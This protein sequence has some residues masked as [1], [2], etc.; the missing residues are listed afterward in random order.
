MNTLLG[1][2]IQQTQAFLENGSR[3]PV[4][5]VMASDNPVLGIKTYATHSALMLGFGKR[6]KPTKA[7]FGIAKKANLSDVPAVIREVRVDEVSV[8][9]GE[10]IKAADVFKPGDIVS[11]TGQSKGKG[12]AGGVKRYHFKGGPRTHGQSDRERAPG[13]IGQTTTPGRVYRGK[14]MAGN[15]GHEQVTVQNLVVIDVDD[16][17]K[18]LLL[19]GLVPGVLG[20]MIKITKTGEVKEKNFSPL[21]KLTDPS[22]AVEETVEEPAVEPEAAPVVETAQEEVTPDEAQPAAEEAPVAAQETS[23]ENDAKEATNNG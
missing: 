15:M 23:E 21:F 7:L 10:S 16:V 20:G 3:I 14:R 8:Q 6:K 18:T 12:F 9:P 4:T 11:V 22:V 1:K 5:V 13:S 19:K 2:K 17:T